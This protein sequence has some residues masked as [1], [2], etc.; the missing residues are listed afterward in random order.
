MY[1]PACV[2]HVNKAISKIPGV[3]SSDVS[4]LTNAL[5]VTFSDDENHDQAVSDSLHK[6]GYG[7]SILS[8]LTYKERRAKRAKENKKELVILLVSLFLLLVL[9]YFAMGMMWSWP[10]ISPHYI[11]IAIELALALAIIGLNYS[12]YY[13]GLLA[14]FSFHPN[15]ESLVSL[16]SLASLGFGIYG[17]VMFLNASDPSLQEYWMNNIYFESAAMIPLFVSLGD[18]LSGLAKD[19]AASS[20][21]DILSIAPETA[22]K[23][24][25]DGS[26]KEIRSDELTIG[27]ICKISKGMK[28]PADGKVILGEGQTSEG[29][30]TG[31]A[32]PVEKRAGSY[33]LGGSLL[34]SG[35]LNMEIEKKPS[36][37][38]IGEV[39]ELVKKA[40]LSKAHIGELADTISACFTPAIMVVSLIVFLCWYL[41]SCDL[42]LALNLA[43]SVLVVSCPCALGLATP[44]AMMVATG[45][46]AS[47]GVL[48]KN[49][50]AF[51]SLSSL[52][53]LIFDKTG[54]LTESFMSISSY[55]VSDNEA[56]IAWLSLEKESHH[57][58]AEA[59]C[60]YLESLGYVAKKAADVEEKEGGISGK[61][62]GV[63]FYSGNEEFMKRQGFEP[64][65][66]H[67][68]ASVSYL[69][70]DKH[71]IYGSISLH[72]APKKGVKEEIASLK[73]KGY[74]ILLLS[75]DNLES[76]SSLAGEVGI[77]EYRASCKPSDKNE[78]IEELKKEGHKVGMIG[79]GINDAP[80]LESSTCGIAIGSG[81]D[82]AL[83]SASMILLK[84]SLSDLSFALL[85]SKKVTNNVK[86]NLFYA[87]IY[88]LIGIP[89]AAGAFHYLGFD[90]SPMLASGLMALSSL[91]VVLN[92]LRLRSFKGSNQQ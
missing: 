9:M 4:L 29:A 31:E 22:Y 23:K 55:T 19:K 45:K 77:E 37:S 68:G 71:G 56:S 88:N 28:I 41:T 46:T 81:S 60:I 21:E 79:D 47:E 74:R 49:A 40:T 61:I 84:D 75:G 64:T 12:Y 82:I 14:L 10:I 16:G 54:T 83:N 87:F 90:L 62:N 17:F 89:I 86:G 11:T 25:E 91:T 27:D 30:L 57:P 3:L 32:L 59:T 52:D 43:L 92:S 73:E 15:M 8:E 33:L 53:T 66:I 20:L 2:R 34:L 51:Y 76:V 50:E 1:C 63:I 36:D 48:I 5:I 35:E 39:G 42:I 69:A 7:V 67:N 6:A 13:R 72:G 26:F 44:L 24:Q 85:Y 18:Y 38:F 80:A 78:L 58:L 70:S 65:P